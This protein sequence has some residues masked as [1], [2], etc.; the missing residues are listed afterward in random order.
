MQVSPEEFAEWRQHPVTEY[1]FGLMERWADR[2]KDEW[3]NLVWAD[4]QLD[5][6]RLIEARVRADCYRALPESDL[7][8]WQAIED[9][10]NDT[11]S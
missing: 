2:Q 10:L 9:K 6:A 11:E 7:S 3:A 4:G 5:Q 8:D 1:V